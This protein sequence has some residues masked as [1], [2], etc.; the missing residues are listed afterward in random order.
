MKKHQKTAL[1]LFMIC[2]LIFLLLWLKGA[3]VPK[4]SG[5]I[6]YRGA[7]S[8]FV[9]GTIG[10]YLK[11]KLRD[12]KNGVKANGFHEKAIEKLKMLLDA[13]RDKDQQ[14][15]LA[16]ASKS[17]KHIEDF[18]ALESSST[19]FR[20]FM[21]YKQFLVSLN[22]HNFASKVRTPEYKKIIL[23]ISKILKK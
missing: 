14:R 17:I 13:L 18:S 6:F 9:L 2:F 21:E 23:I 22:E 3:M 11:D 15:V 19:K 5:Y 16:F 10:W 7:I 12:I 8:L 20:D 1:K 4:S